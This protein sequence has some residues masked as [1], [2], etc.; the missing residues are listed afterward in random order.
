MPSLFLAAGPLARAARLAAGVAGAPRPGPRITGARRLWTEGGDGGGWA[1]LGGEGGEP[2]RRGTGAS[3]GRGG[4]QAGR[5]APG[6]PAR[7]AVPLPRAQRP[8]HLR[9]RVRRA[10]PRAGG[11]GAGLPGPAHRRLAHPDRRGGP[12]G[13]VRAGAPPGADALAGQRLLDRGAGRLGQAHRAHRRR[14]PRL[15]LRAQDRRGRRLPPV[16]AGPAGPGRDQGR[17]QGRGRHHPQRAHDRQRAPAPGPRRPAA[18]VRGQGGDLL[19]LLGVRGPQPADDRRGQAGLRQPPQ[20]RL[21]LAAPEG[22]ED[23]RVAAAG[24]ALPLVR[25]GRRDALRLPLGVPRLLRAGRPA[26]GRPDQERRHPG[27]GGGVRRPLGRAPP[28][29]RVRDRRGGGQGRRQ[30]PP[31]R[32]GPHLQGAALGDRLQVPARGAHH[33][34]Q[35]H[36]GVDRADRGRDPV[37]GAGAGAGR[38]VHG[39]PGHPPQPGRGRPPRRPPR[40]H[41]VRAQGRRRHPRGGRPGPDQAAQAA[42]ALEVPGK[43]APSAAP[44]WSA[45]RGSRPPAA[46]TPPAARPSAGAPWS[47]S[48]AVGPW[49]SS[50][51]GRRPSPP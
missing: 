17:R 11:A 42:A 35:G 38:R 4:C 15:C 47:T 33:P 29:P 21:G 7:R 48:P 14:R 13:G 22:P 12:G 45:R 27:G 32:A 30:R 24:H 6:A 20:R 3:F 10:V 31:E 46:P 23:H 19:P 8:R 26:R 18:R 25:A 49:T 51:W 5:R 28:R 1:I 43:A 36:H 37:R 50:T 9:R 40:R 41:R 16:R 34:A 39:R 44:P 2:S